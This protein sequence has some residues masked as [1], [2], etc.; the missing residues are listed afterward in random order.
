MKPNKSMILAA[1]LILGPGLWGQGK[2]HFLTPAEV[3]KIMDESK[4]VYRL[5]DS[6]AKLTPGE[7]Q[8]LAATLFPQACAPIGYPRL[9]QKD[10]RPSVQ[11]F[12]F[13][14]E[15]VDLIAK[16]ETYFD[17][18]DY[19]GARQ[20]YE[21]ALQADPDC[22]MAIANI[23]DCYQF[24]DQPEKSLLEYEKA[25]L[26]NPADHRLF[27]FRGDALLKLGRLEDAKKSYIHSLMLRPRYS[28]ALKVIDATRELLKTSVRDSLFRP[29]A[30]AR[31]QG[32]EVCVYV[33]LEKGGAPWLAYANAK[34]VWLGEAGHR[35]EMTGR[36]EYAWSMVEER[37]CLANL[38]AV[39]TSSLENKTVTPDP[40]LDILKRIFD[41]GD[42][43]LFILYEIYT[44]IC[45]YGMLVQP[46][47]TQN[48]VE[49][50][51]QKYM[52]S[53]LQ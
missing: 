49:Q 35:L 30:L 14:N 9:V 25:I 22:Y 46:V 11:E 45:P 37:E 4:T 8:D 43:D 21:L 44:R 40:D 12:L 32:E 28:Y 33:D 52:V 38:L 3:I 26:K 6:L 41:N 7:R 51:I 47:E 29:Q 50:Y 17:K 34:A 36:S 18:K 27:F 42:L 19:E 48:K 15:A 53:S 10:G 1:I 5:E 16:A 31:R 2:K 39:Y 20:N 24:S 13:N 23:G